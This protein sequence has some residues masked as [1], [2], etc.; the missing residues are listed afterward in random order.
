MER[1][2]TVC[3]AVVLLMGGVVG[4][5]TVWNPAANG[6]V[7]PATGNWGDA[8]NWTNGLPNT[9]PEDPNGKAVFNVD[10]AAECV[11]TDPQSFTQVVQGDNG[12]GGVIRV[13]KG[14]SLTTG[15]VWSAVGYDNTAHMIVES[16]G[17]VT[18]G[19]HMWVGFRDDSVGTLDLLGGHVRV[20]EMF[21][22]GWEASTGGTGLVNVIAGHLDLHNIHATDSLQD[23]SVLDVHNGIVTIDGNHLNK[24]IDYMAAMKIRG[25]GGKGTVNAAF[26]PET[27]KTIFTAVHPLAVVPST[28]NSFLSAGQVTLSWTL[29][30]PCVPGQAV[31][32]DVY[33]TDD[34]WALMNFT[35]PASIRVLSQSNAPNVTVTVEGQRRYW[36]AVD[37]YVGSPSDPV[38]SPIFSF[39]VG[40]QAPTVEIS[41]DPPAAWLPDGND[42]MLDATITD[43]VT[44]TEQITKTWSV[45]SEPSENAAFIHNVNAEDTLVS[46][47]ELGT[48]T[49]RLTADD[50]EVADNIGTAEIT[51]RV[52]ENSCDAAKSVPGFALMTGD[53][54]ADCRNDF[55]DFAIFADGW[56]DCNAL[57]CNE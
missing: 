1:N 14:G 4:A 8:A 27:N 56:L 49:L 44:E 2:G 26:D 39:Y 31:P 32:V 5:A 40:N 53:L 45:V 35:D 18:F 7:P 52:F 9:G 47:K 46:F 12:P 36:W 29:P 38:Y 3:L 16:G 51:I 37:A 20:S 55:L 54:N 13:V 24:I 41:A 34:Y 17:N 57:G 15:A 33:I 50:G 19:E 21:G 43:D 42:V 48:Y 30:D 11:V 28:E 22:C 6:I 25:F 23:D 10:D